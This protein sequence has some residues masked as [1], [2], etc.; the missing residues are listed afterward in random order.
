MGA[1][2]VRFS[3]YESAYKPRM[4]SD[5]PALV[6][7]LPVIRVERYAPDAR[8]MRTTQRRRLARHMKDIE[9]A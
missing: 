9:D 4:P 6:I 2:I 3:D 5:E 8:P 7:I 1:K